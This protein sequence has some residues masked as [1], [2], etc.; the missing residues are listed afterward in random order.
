[1]VKTQSNLK[2]TSFQF[3]FSFI[4]G[5]EEQPDAKAVFVKQAAPLHEEQRGRE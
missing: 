3:K 1:M 4:T 2:H 5:F